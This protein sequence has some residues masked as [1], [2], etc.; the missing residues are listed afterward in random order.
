MNI[1]V[2]IKTVNKAKLT[3]KGVV[4]NIVILVV[5]DDVTCPIFRSTWKLLMK[6]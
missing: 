3:C 6:V 1:W 4:G 2:N 5:K